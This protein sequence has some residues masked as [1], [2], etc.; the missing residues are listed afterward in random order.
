MKQTSLTKDQEV[1]INHLSETDTISIHP[2]DPSAENIFLEV[3]NRIQA[4]LGKDILLE[5]H[6]ATRFKIS[7]QD[8]LDLYIPVIPEMFEEMVRRVTSLLGPPKSH[9]KLER[10]RFPLF[11][12][13]KKVDVFMV[14]KNHNVWK[15]SVIFE[16]Y[17]IANPNALERYR[18][19]KEEGNGLSV[20]EYYKRKTEFINE[21]VSTANKSHNE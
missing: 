8:E 5:H 9:Y 4:S 3:K 1:W 21:I 19:L 11:V 15:R 12:R 16:E 14:N 10:A 17:L 18:V 7:G 6:G 2:Y 20:R 13:N